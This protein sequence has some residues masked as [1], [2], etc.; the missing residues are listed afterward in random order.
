M[1]SVARHSAVVAVGGHLDGEA[2]GLE[3]A[4]QGGRELGVVLDQQQLHGLHL[5]SSVAARTMVGEHT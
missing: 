2:L 5:R 4:P 3:P 1:P